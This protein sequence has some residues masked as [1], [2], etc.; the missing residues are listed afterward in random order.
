MLARQ[1]GSPRQQFI[2]AISAILDSID[3][4]IIL[5]MIHE[6]KW[7]PAEEKFRLTSLLRW[8]LNNGDLLYF[9]CIRD[10]YNNIV[11]LDTYHK[12]LTSLL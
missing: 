1:S 2:Q 12:A 8:F 9:I 10:R 3:S 11:S 7:V 6:P 5:L 4:H